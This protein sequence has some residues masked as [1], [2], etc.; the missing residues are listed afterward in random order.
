MSAL[1]WVIL[2]AAVLGAIAVYLSW[3][4]GRLDRQH[5]RLDAS[6][7][8]L[9]AQLLRRSGA[10]LDLATSG[11]LD[12]AASMLVADAASR[13][14]TEGEQ[15]P[16]Q[17]QSDLSAVLAAAL[18]DPVYLSELAEDPATAATLDE[19]AGACRRVAHARRFH[20][21]TVNTVRRLRAKRIVRLL[22]LSGHAELPEPIEFDDT[23]PTGLPS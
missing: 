17:V 6:R 7:A 21:V 1:T 4:A 13:A 8:V 19:L 14:R 5:A 9:D 20:N 22:R 23:V 12:P 2:V 10:A 15:S 11:I 16:E 18:D 3:T